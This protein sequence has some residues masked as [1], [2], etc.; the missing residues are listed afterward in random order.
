MTRRKSLS[1]SPRPAHVG[2]DDT[3]ETAHGQKGQRRKIALHFTPVLIEIG[4]ENERI[5]LKVCSCMLSPC[6]GA[7]IYAARGIQA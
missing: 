5:A 1:K 6:N 7:H 4:A 3:Q 2:A